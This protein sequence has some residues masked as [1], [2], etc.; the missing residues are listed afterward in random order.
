MEAKPRCAT[1]LHCDRGPQS[2]THLGNASSLVGGVALLLCFHRDMAGVVVGF[3]DCESTHSP[4]WNC[5]TAPVP[6]VMR[7]DPNAYLSFGCGTLG[8]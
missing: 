6:N 8:C 7:S 2:A 3:S 5:L 1:R 4:H